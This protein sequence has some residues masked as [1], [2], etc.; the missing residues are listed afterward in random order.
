M[1]E[2]NP[3]VCIRAKYRD[4]HNQ[5]NRNRPIDFDYCKTALSDSD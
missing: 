3:G 1:L 4:A 2:V 5:C